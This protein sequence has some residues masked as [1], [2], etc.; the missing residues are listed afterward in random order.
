MLKVLSIASY[1]FLPAK[2]GGQKGIAFFNR[3]FAKH[4]SFVC[5]SV[6]ENAMN[7]TG[8]YD[9]IP[10][11]GS[12]RFRYINLLLFFRIR[13]YIR[14]HAITHV[15]L[16]HPY[17]GWLGYLLKKF[18]GITLVIHSHNIEALRFRDIGKWW[19]KLLWYYERSCFRI[20]DTSFFIS[21]ED[22]QYAI[23]TYGVSAH[24]SIVVTYGTT[25]NTTPSMAEKAQAKEA[26]AAVHTFNPESLVLL[27]S[28]AFNYAPNLKGLDDILN[29]INPAL[30]RENIEY[31]I[32]I[33]G[34][35]LPDRY[36]NLKQYQNNNIIFAGFVEDINMYF[37]AADIFLNPISEGGGI[38]TKLVEA[39]SAN[40]SC[41]SYKTGAYGVP[42]SVTGTK[43]QIVSDNDSAAFC[44]A[45][46]Q[47]VPYIGTQ[48]PVSFLHHFYWD[49]IA[50]TAAQKLQ[51]DYS[52]S[53]QPV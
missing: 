11:L 33:S 7:N 23:R 31:K 28:A 47:S 40:T 37:T 35:H 1:Q 39:L 12:G 52:P 22:R 26:V 45:I 18:A 2:M 34:S 29:N 16:E 50:Q 15:L 42:L 48:I 4:I 41:I 19:W 9:I 49:N 5:I 46:V 8:Q 44:Q 20:A 17:Y 30:Q 6:P 32:I 10:M 43:L 3:F 38:K 25:N 53:S 14:Q 24:K 13:K 27:Y 21:E 36:D 51:N